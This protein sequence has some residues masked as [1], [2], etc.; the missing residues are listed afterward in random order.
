MKN[1]E[2]EQVGFARKFARS[3]GR[4]YYHPIS[5]TNVERIPASGPIL[6]IAN[7][8]NSLLDPVIIGIAI[9][10]PVHFLAKAPLFETPVLGGILRAVG[11]VPAYRAMDSRAD[12]EKNFESLKAA[13]ALLTSGAVVGIFPEGKSHDLL[14]LEKVRSGAARMALEA[15]QQGAGNLVILPAGINYHHK[16]QFRS[17]VCVCIGEP[18]NVAEWAAAHP[19]EPARQVRLLTNE[20]AVLLRK[21]VIHL[22]PSARAADLE[23]VELLVNRLLPPLPDPVAAIQRRKRIADIINHLFS[24]NPEYAQRMSAIFRQYRSELERHGLT[25]DAAPVTHRHHRSAQTSSGQVLWNLLAFAPALAGALHHFL[26]FLIVR[27]MATLWAAK[28]GRTVLSLARLSL[29]IPLYALWYALV[30]RALQPQIGTGPTLAWIMA[31]P[32]LGAFSLEYF[33]QLKQTLKTWRAKQSI[34]RQSQELESLRDTEQLLKQEFLRLA[35]V[36]LSEPSE[37]PQP[38]V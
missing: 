15:L 22:E 16:E 3:L 12:L 26:P 24:T 31:A 33:R 19:A 25:M 38:A 11:M 10:R 9:K 23:G 5:V 28:N 21:V 18:L 34:A 8:A 36:E 20:L 29:S 4:L 35:H 27:S 13:A 2:A 6:V 37:P 1:H 32:F 30:W 14:H 7:H 17:A